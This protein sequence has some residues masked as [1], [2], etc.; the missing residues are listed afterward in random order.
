LKRLH[1]A[2]GACIIFPLVFAYFYFMFIARYVLAFWFTC[3]ESKKFEIFLDGKKHIAFSHKIREG[4][5][6]K[7]KSSQNR[8]KAKRNNEL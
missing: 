4:F 6:Q 1:L 7:R 5:R 8:N 3:D 2:V